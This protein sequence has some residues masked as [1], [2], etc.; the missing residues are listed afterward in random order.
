[1]RQFDS[2]IALKEEMSYWGQTTKAR[3]SFGIDGQDSLP[4]KA[5]TCPAAKGCSA[6]EQAGYHH[7]AGVRAAYLLAFVLGQ[8]L[9]LTLFTPEQP[10]FAPELRK[11]AQTRLH[12][13]Q[14]HLWVQQALTQHSSSPELTIGLYNMCCT[15][16]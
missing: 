11:P 1:M 10:W 4:L 13:M 8:E 16:R 14:T 7:L 15:C 6:H 3:D 5:N 9:W 2:P 12:R